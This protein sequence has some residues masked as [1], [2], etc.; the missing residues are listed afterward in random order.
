MRGQ[1]QDPRPAQLEEH[2]RERVLVRVRSRRLARHLGERAG[3]RLRLR[4]RSRQ[5]W[6]FRQV[7]HGPGPAGVPDTARSRG[8]VEVPFLLDR[9]AVVAL[10]GPETGDPVPLDG[11][12]EP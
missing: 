9:L 2:T 7:Y 6:D 12:N 11:A 10:A 5:P 1:D 8:E 3:D 4:R